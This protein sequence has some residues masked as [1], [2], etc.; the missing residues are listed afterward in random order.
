MAGWQNIELIIDLV[1]GQQHSHQERLVLLFQWNC[2]TI[3]YAAQHF[4]QLGYSVVSFR[5]VNERVEDVV[6]LLADKRS[7]SHKFAVDPMA[8]RF[9]EVL[10][11]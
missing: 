8:Y 9:E 5:L 2:K 11:K 1:K 7:D 3:D 6:D 10:G 4:Q